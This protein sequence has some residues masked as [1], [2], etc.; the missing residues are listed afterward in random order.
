MKKCLNEFA[1]QPWEDEEF[2]KQ[3]A[4][5]WEISSDEVHYGWLSP[6]E[7]SLNLF[8]ELKLENANV[9]DVGWGFFI[10]NFLTKHNCV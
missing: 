5:T 8:S 4:A 2:C 1:T 7:S 3:Y 6:G 10:L 9:L